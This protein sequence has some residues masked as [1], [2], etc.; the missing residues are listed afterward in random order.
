MRDLT[1]ECFNEKFNLM[2]EFTGLMGWEENASMKPHYDSNRDYLLQRHYTGLLYLNSA[3]IDFSGGSFHFCDAE[4]HSRCE[5][6][7]QAGLLLMF[8]SGPENIHKLDRVSKGTRFVLTM[9]FTKE[10]SHDEDFKLMS[11]LKMLKDLKVD[12]LPKKLIPLE[13]GMRN[14]DTSTPVKTTELEMR[15]LISLGIECVYERSDGL[16]IFFTNNAMLPVLFPSRSLDLVLDFFSYF[17]WQWEGV[18][19]HSWEECH[20]RWIS[21]KEGCVGEILGKVGHWEDVGF[22]CT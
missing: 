2:V 16:V 19:N 6:V 18:P 12:R 21:Y 9:W 14:Q 22:L 4:G 17:Q 11:G 3:G 13:K 7:P 5:I 1:E 15:K 10:K 20:E 8:S